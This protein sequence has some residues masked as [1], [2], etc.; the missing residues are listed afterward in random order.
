M[1]SKQLH[2]GA[3]VFDPVSSNNSR[4]EKAGM[5][6]FPVTDV[7][8]PSSVSSW[9]PESSHLSFHRAFGW[10]VTCVRRTCPPPDIYSATTAV[11]VAGPF[12]ITKAA[13]VQSTSAVALVRAGLLDVLRS[14]PLRAPKQCCSQWPGPSSGGGNRPTSREHGAGASP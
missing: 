10:D 11:L 4:L 3:R 6:Q 14:L 5:L 9:T 7:V 8:S 12:Q 1:T 2:C 13:C